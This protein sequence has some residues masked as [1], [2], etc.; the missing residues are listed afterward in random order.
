MTCARTKQ[1]SFEA[2]I[3]FASLSELN[4]ATPALTAVGF[5]VDPRP[6][7]AIPTY[8]TMKT[9]SSSWCGCKCSRA[10]RC[11]SRRCRGG[12]RAV[13]LLPE[14][15]GAGWSF[16]AYPTGYAPMVTCEAE[17]VF[18]TQPCA[19]GGM[20]ALLGSRVCSGRAIL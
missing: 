7:G 1:Q 19:D 2:E 8:R 10:K 18:A 12:H 13:R 17:I 14:L 15:W 11:L 16:Y 20:Q 9:A 3:L 5:E 6:I 4:A